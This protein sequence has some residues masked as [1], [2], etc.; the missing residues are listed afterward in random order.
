MLSLLVIVPAKKD[1][2]VRSHSKTEPIVN[3]NIDMKVSD[4][5]ILP[6][7]KQ[8]QPGLASVRRNKQNCLILKQIFS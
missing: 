5:Q 2:M 3:L 1:A 7:M 6:S 8:A 4:V